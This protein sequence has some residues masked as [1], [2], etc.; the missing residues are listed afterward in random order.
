M[1]EDIVDKL[2]DLLLQATTE[3]S[4][5]Y[6]ASCC[7]DA[8]AEIEKLRATLADLY[9]GRAAVLPKTRRHAL[10]LLTI[11]EVAVNGNANVKPLND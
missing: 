5:F 1:R 3:R 9:D 6:V 8:I 2:K 7:Q 10:D 4:H 11:A